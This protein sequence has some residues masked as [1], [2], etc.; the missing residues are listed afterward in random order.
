VLLKPSGQIV[1]IGI[2]DEAV[3]GYIQLGVEYLAGT[4]RQVVLTAGH[5]WAVWRLRSSIEGKSQAAA[6]VDK[7]KEDPSPR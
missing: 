6:S 1:R 5:E 3:S 2:S 7:Y 4:R